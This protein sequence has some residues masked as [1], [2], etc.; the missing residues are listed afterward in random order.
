MTAYDE[1]IALH[2]PVPS[3]LVLPDLKGFTLEEIQNG[4]LDETTEDPLAP[5]IANATALRDA[6]AN[7]LTLTQEQ[8]DAAAP[9]L[10][11]ALQAA[12]VES[13][14]VDNPTLNL[15]RSEITSLAV[16]ALAAR[17]V[18]PAE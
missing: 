14:G 12:A 7:H 10:L 9:N 16:A 3:G 8:K 1:L 6:L 18:P 11:A 2:G 17:I 13:V 5:M 15:L 4:A